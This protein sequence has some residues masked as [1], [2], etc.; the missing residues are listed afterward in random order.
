[1]SEMGK[2]FPDDLFLLHAKVFNRNRLKEGT[3][4]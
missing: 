2:Y 3:D 4:A 1:M